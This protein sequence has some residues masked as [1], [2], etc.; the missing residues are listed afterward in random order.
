M[1]ASKYP[2]LEHGMNLISD[3]PSPKDQSEIER[4]YIQSNQIEV[5]QS[6]GVNGAGRCSIVSEIIEYFRAQAAEVPEIKKFV[7]SL[8]ETS[9]GQLGNE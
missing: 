8:L 7:N 2:T 6:H 9:L 3:I 5:L 4:F 1:R